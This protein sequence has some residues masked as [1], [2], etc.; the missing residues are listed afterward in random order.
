MAP[1]NEDL[2]A[3]IRKRYQ[4]VLVRIA[5]A[6]ASSAFVS[7]AVRVVVVSKAQPIRVVRAAIA[8]GISL[9]GENY[10]EEAAEK[11]ATLK[12]TGVEWHMIGHV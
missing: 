5:E 7:E 12:E 6:R 10:V 2:V 4:Q 1:E 11:I 3:A 8:A 9:F